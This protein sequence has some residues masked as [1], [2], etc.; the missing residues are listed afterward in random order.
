MRLQDKLLRLHR[1][2]AHG[3]FRR[4][5]VREMERLVAGLDSH[6]VVDFLLDRFSVTEAGEDL[7]AKVTF[8]RFLPRHVVARHGTPRRLQSVLLAPG[9]SLEAEVPD[10]VP[11]A[12]LVRLCEATLRTVLA[13]LPGLPPAP[14]SR[15]ITALVP[16]QDPG[17]EEALLSLAMAPEPDPYAAFVLARRDTDAWKEAIPRLADRVRDSPDLL[18]TLTAGSAPS[19][20]SRPLIDRAVE[21]AARHPHPA[22]LTMEGMDPETRGLIFQQIVKTRRGWAIVQALASLSRTGDRRDLDAIL[23]TLRSFD[24]PILRAEAARSLGRIPDERARAACAD[25]IASAPSSVEAAAALDSL[26]RQGVPASDRERIFGLAATSRSPEVLAL[27]CLGRLDL[28]PERCAEGISRLLQGDATERRHGLHALAYLPGTDAERLLVRHMLEDPG[29]DLRHFSA[30]LMGYR[31]PSVELSM[32]L[33]APLERC[34]ESVLP[35]AARAAVHAADPPESGLVEALDRRRRAASD[36]RTR[37]ELLSAMG[38]TGLPEARDRIE[39]VLAGGAS[40]DPQEIR[41]ALEGIATSARPWTGMDLSRWADGPDAAI[42]AAATLA[43]LPADAARAARTLERLVA[44]DDASFSHGI[45]ALE[46]MATIATRC[47]DHPRY[48][49]WMDVIRQAGGRPVPSGI[50]PAEAIVTE[51]PARELARGIDRGAA[52]EV[53]RRVQG[54]WD[55]PV[56]RRTRLQEPEVDPRGLESVSGIRSRLATLVIFLTIFLPAVLVF[57]RVLAPEDTARPGAGSAPSDFVI[58]EEGDLVVDGARAAQ[59][60]LIGL[61]AKLTTSKEDVRISFQVSGVALTLGPDSV[62]SLRAVQEVGKDRIRVHE[63]HDMKG[64]IQVKVPPERS[65]VRAF[66]GGTVL[67][68]GAGQHRLV[69]GEGA[70]ELVTTQGRSFTVEASGASRFHD[71]PRWVKLRE[72]RLVD[73]GEESP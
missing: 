71:A 13:R 8:A 37:R 65:Q 11:P 44:G 33:A 38:R 25:L 23:W 35:L 53:A 48:V 6:Q 68:L 29:E 1:A 39:A 12:E 7:Q 16:F 28:E 9:S 50:R 67:G 47:A 52:L 17:I 61:P 31:P 58:L 22:A 73:E 51:E 64:K 42:A 21:I 20:A 3:S 46:S 72:G 41:G 49:H 19:P 55:R 4:Y 60:S 62:L 36:P 27:A 30:L 24:H 32:A 15:V 14:R 57:H 10:A 59:G 54:G 45:L 56:P 26:V 2:H 5:L 66:S 40:V 70:V 34:E 63:L 69:A 43:L 18:L